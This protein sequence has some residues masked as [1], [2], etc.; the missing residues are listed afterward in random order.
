MA[1]QLSVE[2]V[3]LKGAVVYVRRLVRA[4]EKRVMINVLHSPI[5]VS[6]KS[7]VFPSPLLVGNVQPICGYEV[8][9]SEVEL[10][11]SLEFLDAQAKM[12]QLR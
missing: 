9:I 1:K 10:P 4:Q 2:I 3:N 8:E 5:D 6:E 12:A 7:N 11:L